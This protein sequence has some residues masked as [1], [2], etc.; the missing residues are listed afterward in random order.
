V[1]VSDAAG[2][3]GLRRPGAYDKKWP[4]A[5]RIFRAG[6]FT[7]AEPASW[8]DC[9]QEASDNGA[10]IVD[11]Y[12]QGGAFPA[13]G[14][15]TEDSGIMMGDPAA[16]IIAD[17]YAFGATNFD[18]QAALNG[19]VRARRIHRQCAADKKQMSVTRWM[20]I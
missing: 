15:V 17:G 3:S 11:G 4:G 1:T 13:W 19:L 16:A 12:Q 6:T 9:A 7:G 10:I 2:V 5:I 18:T 20:I 14:V 8:N